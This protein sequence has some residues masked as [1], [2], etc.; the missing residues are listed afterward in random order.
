MSS[1]SSPMSS[2]VTPTKA[3]ALAVAL[4]RYDDWLLHDM[5]GGPRPLK[6]AWV[7]NTQ[8]AGT[9]FFLGLLM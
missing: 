5:F 8:K 7:I 6:F 4:R 2:T 3:P 9:F 1:T